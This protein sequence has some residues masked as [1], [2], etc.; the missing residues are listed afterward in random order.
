VAFV[1]D[2]FSRFIVGWRVSTSLHTELALDA[3]EMAIWRRQ[4]LDL[5]GLIHHSDRGVL[6]GFN[7]SS[8][9]CSQELS[10]Q[11]PS[12]GAQIAR[13]VPECSHQGVHRLH[14]ERTGNA[15]G[16]QLPKA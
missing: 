15:S 16:Q 4:R 10:W 1:T 3:L 8:Q 2:V 13:Y 6:T 11:N 12:G 14:V 9:R 5:T 7:E